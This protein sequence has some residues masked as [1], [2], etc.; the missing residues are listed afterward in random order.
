MKL[1]TYLNAMES[2][3]LLIEESH[4]ENEKHD[5]QYRAFRARILRMD[6]EKDLRIEKLESWIKRN[7]AIVHVHGGG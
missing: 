4:G 3:L 7:A 5:R 1:E 2:A 6:K